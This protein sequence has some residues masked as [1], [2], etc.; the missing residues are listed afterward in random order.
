MGAFRTYAKNREGDPKYASEM[1]D[2]V[3][4]TRADRVTSRMQT[5]GP[6]LALNWV[7]LY[8]SEFRSKV[9]TVS[10]S[11]IPLSELRWM[12]RRVGRIIDRLPPASR[13]RLYVENCM[14]LA[15]G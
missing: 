13:R 11:P 9:L 10:D 2:G 7:S 14:G 15:S 5:G 4:H 6:R 12:W 3:V 1:S 8:V